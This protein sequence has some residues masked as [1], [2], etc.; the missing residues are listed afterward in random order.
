[1]R[2]LRPVVSR[3]SSAGLPRTGRPPCAFSVN[4][5]A[6]MKTKPYHACSL[7]LP[8]AAHCLFRLVFAFIL[9]SAILTE[10]KADLVIAGPCLD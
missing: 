1:V 2:R 10:L 9:T 3:R 4:R 8:Q 7:T 6:A 5:K